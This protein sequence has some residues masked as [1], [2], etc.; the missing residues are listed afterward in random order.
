MPHCRP[1]AQA[2]VGVEYA[3]SRQGR[4]AAVWTP[5]MRSRR[6]SRRH[7]LADCRTESWSNACSSGLARAGVRAGPFPSRRR[8]WRTGSD[9]ACTEGCCASSK[10]SAKDRACGARWLNRPALRKACQAGRREQRGGRTA[11]VRPMPRASSHGLFSMAFPCVRLL[12]ARGAQCAPRDRA[13]C[14][15]R[16]SRLGWCCALICARRLLDARCRPAREIHALLVLG[17]VRSNHGSLVRGGAPVCTPPAC[18]GQR[19]MP[20]CQCRAAS[21]PA[22]TQALCRGHARRSPPCGSTGYR[23]HHQRL[24][25]ERGYPPAQLAAATLRVIAAAVH[26]KTFLSSGR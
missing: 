4:G 3:T 8:R 20:A 11:R 17:F 1:V 5:R 2:E 21:L 26:L 24:A 16:F 7:S 14:R 19:A 22:R 9:V 25:R 6:K 23:A 10:S 15:Q 13:F 18:L 12:C